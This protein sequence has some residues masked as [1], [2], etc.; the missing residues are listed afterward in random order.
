MEAKLIDKKT[1]NILKTLLVES[2]SKEELMKN[3]SMKSSTLYKHLNL[4]KKAGYEIRQ[5]DL[6]YELVVCKNVLTFA[7]YELNLFSY[8][9][10]IAYLMLPNNKFKTL[11]NVINKFLTLTNKNDKEIVQK[12][13]KDLKLTS[14]NNCYF[15]KISILKKYKDTKKNVL[16]LCKDSQEFNILPKD[17]I[18]NK[19]KLYLEYY[20]EENRLKKI[21]IDNIIKIFENKNENIL[22]Q[23]KETIFELHGR[24]A[25]SYLLKENE[26]I[27]DFTKEKIVIANSSKDKIALFRR[28]LR[29]D[30]LCKVTFPKTDVLSFKELIEKSLANIDKF[31]DNI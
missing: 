28:L 16:I 9:L 22:S 14:M 26:R 24:L 21:L 18:W 23:T 11:Q 2:S 25:K 30:T 19:N 20:D 12:K 13:Y 5:E 6:F 4:I 17:Y 29:Y 27:I 1:L 31:L 3:F 7:D 8:F 15:E 10:L